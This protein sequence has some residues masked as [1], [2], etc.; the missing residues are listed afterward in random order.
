MQPS[1]Q[2][3]LQFVSKNLTTFLEFKEQIKN[4]EEKFHELVSVI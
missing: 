2:I 3:L 4:N 1:E